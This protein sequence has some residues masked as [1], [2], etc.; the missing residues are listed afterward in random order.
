M[1]YLESEGVGAAVVGAVSTADT[2]E[3]DEEV[4]HSLSDDAS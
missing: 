3:S 4:D 2:S 1:R